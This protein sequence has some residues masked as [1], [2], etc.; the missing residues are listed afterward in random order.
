MTEDQAPAVL[1]SWLPLERVLA[2]LQLRPEDDQAGVVE[3][4]RQAAADYLEQQRPDLATD[5]LQLDGTPAPFAATPALVQAGVLAAAR[6]YARRGSPAGL[7]S[8]GEF[9]AAEVLRLDP[10]VAR[11]AGLGRHAV[12]RIG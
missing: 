9:G 1:S 7:A 10:D 5:Q 4:C 2:W 8:F 3:L 11:L 6:L 12:P